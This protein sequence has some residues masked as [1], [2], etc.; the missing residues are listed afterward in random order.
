MYERLKILRKKLKLTQ[1]AFATQLG[2]KQNTIASYEL[3]RIEPSNS[4]ISLICH[5][6]NVNEKWLRTGEGDIFLNLPVEDEY[7]KAATS[8]SNDPLV[9]SALIGY[10]KLNSREREAVMQYITLIINEME[11]NKQTS[12]TNSPTETDPYS[13]IPFDPDELDNKY[14]PNDS[15]KNG[16]TG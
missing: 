6:F 5:E 14:F 16:K 1:Q 12:E 15:K 4:V 10:Y 7:F 11:I 9:V 13:D 8:L 2:L 3:N